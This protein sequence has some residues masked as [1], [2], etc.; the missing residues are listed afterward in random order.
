[1]YQSSTIITR[2]IPILKNHDVEK[3][4]V[5][6]SF[7]RDENVACS[8]LDLMVRYAK[9]KTFFEIHELEQELERETGLK[10]DVVS[11]KAVKPTILPY[12]QRD[13]KALW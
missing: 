9:P 11:E 12:I 10:V 4:Y 7:A 3:S 8:D 6:G 13:M 2:I 1:M 5:F